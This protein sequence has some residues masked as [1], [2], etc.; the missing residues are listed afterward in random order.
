M[1]GLLLVGLLLPL[2][3]A[4]E[5]A[6]WKISNGQ[7]ELYIG[8]TVHVLSRQDY[9]L[10]REFEQAYRR[11]EKLVLETDLGAMEQPEIQQRLMQLMTYQGG[12]SLKDDL[13]PKTYRKLVDY[14][15]KTT[16]SLEILLGFKPSMVALTLTMA[17]LQRLGMAETGV[18]DYFNKAAL[19]DGKPLGQL[20]T[21]E[22]Q[23]DLLANMGEGQ[24]DEMILSTIEELEQLP[25]LMNDLKTAWR[26]G[27]LGSLEQIA[28]EPMRKEF[29]DLYRS[30]L[31]SRNIG[32]LPKI[33]A[34]LQ[35]PEKEFVLVGALHL[36][37][38]EGVIQQLRD[39][40][41]RVEFFQ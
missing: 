27:D 26:A 13:S 9:P 35:T 33:E 14:V 21:V 31:V 15:A 29:P 39:R 32:W 40:G 8:G 1:R 16:L 6:V 3:V 23:I 20:E 28:I 41:Y 38:K 12:R 7:S 10:P 5:A 25:A 4:A 11:A 36:A 30:L 2:Q 37:A 18:D 19:N 17:E 34:M 24:E 22:R